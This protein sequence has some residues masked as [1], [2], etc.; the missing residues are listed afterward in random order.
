MLET[1]MKKLTEAIT[2]LTEAL[3]AQQ[4]P[5]ATEPKEIQ[6]LPPVEQ[7]E[8]PAQLQPEAQESC[9]DLREQITEACLDITRTVKG[10]K[11][12]IRDLFTTYGAKKVSD[13]KDGDLLEILVALTLLRGAA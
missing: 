7:E 8:A 5:V 3:Q 11:F 13:I 9:D 6:L 12:N 2:A 1:E 10:G 4:Q